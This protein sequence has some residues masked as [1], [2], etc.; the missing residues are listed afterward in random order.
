LTHIPSFDKRTEHWNNSGP[1]WYQNVKC[2]ISISITALYVEEEAS[3]PIKLALAPSP[4]LPSLFFVS[5]LI[6]VFQRKTTQNESQQTTSLKASARKQ[7]KS[8]SQVASVASAQAR[9]SK[10][11]SRLI[12]CMI[13]TIHCVVF[14]IFK[15]KRGE[16]NPRNA[17]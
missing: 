10:L 5:D 12:H 2:I 3:I 6:L 1:A 9:N 17:R 13:D 8:Q 4:F 16:G 11:N 15:L 14:R 7:V